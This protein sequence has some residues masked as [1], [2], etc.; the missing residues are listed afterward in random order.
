MDNIKLKLLN[1]NVKWEMLN[2]RI[3]NGND[4]K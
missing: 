4:V 3:T 1:G 2:G